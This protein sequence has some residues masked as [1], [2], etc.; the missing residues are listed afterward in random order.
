MQ[1]TIRNFWSQF[2]MTHVCIICGHVHDPLTEGE[3]DNL[4][5][6]FECPECGCGKQDYETVEF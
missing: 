2:K 1:T 5:M 4:P 6:D 3:W